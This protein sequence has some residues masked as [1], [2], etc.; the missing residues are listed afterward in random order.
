M[1]DKDLIIQLQQE[2]IRKLNIINSGKDRIMHKQNIIDDQ[3]SV[4]I[5]KKQSLINLLKTQA[6]GLE[7]RVAELE[8]N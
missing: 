8:R 5:E 7:A 3:K 4:I 6:V 1:I 2:D